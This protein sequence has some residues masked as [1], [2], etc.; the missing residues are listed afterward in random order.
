MV[1]SICGVYKIENSVTGDTYIG[2]SISIKSRWR[3][4]KNHLLKNKHHSKYLQRAYNKYG[5]EAFTFEILSETTIPES[6]NVIE[7]VF[8]NIYSPPYNSCPASGSPRGYQH[9]E[10]SVL[11]RC[12]SITLFSPEGI[13]VELTNIRKFCRE[14]NLDRSALA[15][16]LSNR[17]GEHKG[18][19][20]SLDKYNLLIN[21]GNFN[22]YAKSKKKII[23]LLNTGTGKIESFYNTTEFSRKKNLNRSCLSALINGKVKTSQGYKLKELQ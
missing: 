21:Y 15:K 3:K 1:T 17:Q 22:S 20:S 5:K 13:K 2:Q 8:M 10:E 16:V 6:L 12:K 11:K 23:K 9:S 7:Q 14:N 19:T 18:W 4:H